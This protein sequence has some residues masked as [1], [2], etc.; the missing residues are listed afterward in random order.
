MLSLGED[1]WELPGTSEKYK[2]PEALRAGL[3]LL[4]V[5]NFLR[6]LNCAAFNQKQICNLLVPNLCFSS[7]GE[8]VL[9][10]MSNA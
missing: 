4:R 1:F 7:V 9:I 2:S 10:L 3:W 6:D 8:N 5:A